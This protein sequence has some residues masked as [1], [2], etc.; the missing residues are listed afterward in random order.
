MW[1]K[2]SMPGKRKFADN[3]TP[4]MVYGYT[5]RCSLPNSGGDLMTKQ[6]RWCVP[7]WRA[8]SYF[9]RSFSAT[10]SVSRLACS[11]HSWAEKLSQGEMDAFCPS[12]VPKSFHLLQHITW[13]IASLISVE[14]TAVS[15]THW[16]CQ[17]LQTPENR[18]ICQVRKFS[19]WRNG[20]PFQV[21]W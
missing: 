19:L 6:N 14:K 12:L 16:D 18:K 1:A 9:L 10:S 11:N 8:F 2:F 7:W 21:P 15:Q 13:F 20:S 17:G 5:F 3:H 4:L